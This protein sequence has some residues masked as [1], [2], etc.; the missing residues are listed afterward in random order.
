MCELSGNFM[1]RKMMDDFVP[2]IIEFLDSFGT[3][4]SI[5]LKRPLI[6]DEKLLVAV[7]KG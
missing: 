4:T 5:N 3:K 7:V 2:R 1:S 6:A